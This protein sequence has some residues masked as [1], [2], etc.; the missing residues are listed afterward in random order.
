M[1]KRISVAVLIAI[2]LCAFGW[3]FGRKAF[4]GA[5]LTVWWFW[6]GTA[7][8]AQANV[9]LHNLTGGKWGEPIR[10]P[11]MRFARTTWIASLLFLPVLIGMQ[12]LFPWAPD[13]ARGTARWAGEL[14][15][16]AFKNAW[17][18]PG[19]FVFR[20]ILYLLVWCVLVLL[21]QRESLRRSAPF[22]AAALI[23]YCF[24]V[25]LASADWVMSLT[26]LWYSSVFGWL[27]GTGQM[28]AGLAFA[29]VIA[30]R[31][32]STPPPSIFRDLGN[33]LLMYVM[34][35]AYLAFS[36]F[37]IIW[38]ENLPHEIV[39]YA[40][41]DHGI[42]LAWSWMLA[43]CFFFLPLLILLS[44]DTK[45][46]AFKLGKLAAALLAIQLLNC[47]WLILP[48]LQVPVFQ[49][50]WAMPLCLIALGGIA[51]AL[52]PWRKEGGAHA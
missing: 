13:A 36:E 14:S 45:Q 16:P 25:G 37:L 7:L 40:Q 50:L 48:S 4:L 32:V 18:M 52:R 12:D 26:P 21:A 15:S 46:S 34:T 31:Q 10:E 20:S 9:W 8:G 33:L 42:W 28:L 3:A 19:A 49:W 29:I 5:Y 47:C 30:A 38:A 17:L 39:W 44:R 6:M 11:L 27:V 35:W 51:F 2:V 24:S 1:K 22:A 43:L 23:V 41:R